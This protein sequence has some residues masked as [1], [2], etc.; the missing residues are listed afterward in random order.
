MTMNPFEL[1]NLAVEFDIDQQALSQR[2]LTL[3]KAF[4]PDNFAS[5]SPQEQRLAMQKSAEINDALQI[6]KDPIT[7]ANAIITL[8]TGTAE[9]IEQKSTHDMAF[10]MQQ[11]EWRET[12][13][14]IEQSKEIDELL[15]FSEQ[16][17]QENI[18]ITFQLSQALKSQ[19]WQ[20]ALA[21]T[22]KLRFLRKMLSEIERVEE[23]LA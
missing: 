19:Q 8:H 23:L 11:M 13:E 15:G 1:F 20:V 4:H 9:N 21:I 7:R 6:L 17:E 2:Y 18:Q 3:Q 10:L 12:L 5:H 16:I 22:D 14:Q